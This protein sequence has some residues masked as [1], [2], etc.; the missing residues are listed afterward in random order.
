MSQS[1]GEEIFTTWTTQFAPEISIVYL[2]GELDASTAP[3]FLAGAQALV[4]SHQDILADVH[5]LSYVDSTGLSAL[6]S[7]GNALQRSGKKLC[8]VGCHGLLT[9]IIQISQIHNQ[10]VCYADV[11]QAVQDLKKSEA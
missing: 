4:D 1:N 11:D 6:L 8:L 5:L 7:V 3:E 9:K 2:C 10:L